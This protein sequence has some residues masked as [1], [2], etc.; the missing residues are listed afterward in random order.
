MSEGKNWKAYIGITTEPTTSFNQRKFHIY[1][2]ELNPLHEGDVTP[3]YTEFSVNLKNHATNSTECKKVKLT[4]TVTADYFGVE[5]TRSVPTMVK[6]QQVI[7]LNFGTTDKYYWI[8]LERDD[9][10]K[11]FER[12][13]LSCANIAMTNKTPAADPTD[14]KAKKDGLTD[15]NTY[16]FEMDT[17]DRKIIRL[18][19]SD[20]DGEP[21][22]YYFYIDPEEQSI[23][24]WDEHTDKDDPDKQPPNII[25]IES[26]PMPEIKGRITMQNA[27]GTTIKLEGEDMYVFVPR[28][29]F[30]DVRGDI[31]TNVKNN[32]STNIG[33]CNSLTIVED[34]AVYIGKSQGIDIGE[35]DKLSVGKD[36][37][38][39]VGNDYTVETTGTFTELQ[40]KRDSTTVTAVEWHSTT[41]DLKV[42]DSIKELSMSYNLSTKELDIVSQKFTHS[43]NTAN[44]KWIKWDNIVMIGKPPKGVPIPV[45]AIV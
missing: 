44:L 8:P 12:Y 1:I 14:I 13:R 36:K 43:S 17:R 3:E 19:T 40:N 38:E 5:S 26:R 28:N 32:V 18:Q 45:A 35:N 22:R 11:T 16:F 41:W 10:L 34:N 24:L 21:W 29:M 42:K 39:E 15:D 20:S 2:P 4:K 23:T 37:F 31:L 9:Y 25:K 33:K 27:S 30:V 7:V 6:G